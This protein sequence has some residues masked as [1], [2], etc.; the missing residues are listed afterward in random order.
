MKAG[1]LAGW[2]NCCNGF[3][4]WRADQ[5]EKPQ[6]LQPYVGNQLPHSLEK[7]EKEPL[8]LIAAIQETSSAESSR[9][10]EKKYIYVVFAKETSFQPEVKPKSQTVKGL[11]GRARVWNEQESLLQAGFQGTTSLCLYA[12]RSPSSHHMK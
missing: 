9:L 7:E 5:E 11:G 6:V 1:H 12:C 3:R 10:W 4:E 8:S 2:I